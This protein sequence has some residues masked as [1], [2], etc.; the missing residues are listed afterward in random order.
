MHRG[1]VHVYLGMDL[2]N[3]EEGKCKVSMIK[4]H[5]KVLNKLPEDIVESTASLSS[6]LLFQV[7][8]KC[9]TKRLPE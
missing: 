1:K 5:D 8:E 4:Y 9:K 6:E 3:Y 2:E 7:R